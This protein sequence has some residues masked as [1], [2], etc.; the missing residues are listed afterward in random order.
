MTST[1][2]VEPMVEILTYAYYNSDENIKDL[3]KVNEGIENPTADQ[4][5]KARRVYL[6]NYEKSKDATKEKVQ[7]KMKKGVKKVESK[8]NNDLNAMQKLLD[9]TLA[10]LR[11][12]KTK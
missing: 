11:T 6:A 2:R 10:R 12:M 1:L 3:M 5:A 8:S 4:I 7:K 9:A